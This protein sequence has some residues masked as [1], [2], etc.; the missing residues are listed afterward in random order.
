MALRQYGRGET[1]DSRWRETVEEGLRQCAAEE[2]QWA[3][4]LR[5]RYIQRLDEAVVVER[6]F[7]CRSSYYRK[8][9]EALSVVA[10]EAAKRGLL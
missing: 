5:M 7:I 10:V 1:M 2:P 3:E 9:L 6:M 4:L 8:E